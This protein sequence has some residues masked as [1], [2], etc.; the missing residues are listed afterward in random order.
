M[1]RSITG[2]VSTISAFS[3]V[4]GYSPVYDLLKSCS[5]MLEGAHADE[6]NKGSVTP[7]WVAG[8]TFVH[9]AW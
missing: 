4:T 3:D 1:S 9:M 6:A 7:T 8:V 2:S 5:N